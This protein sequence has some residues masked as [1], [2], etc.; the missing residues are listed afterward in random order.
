MLT[1]LPVQQQPLSQH[2]LARRHLVIID[3]ALAAADR[4]EAATRTPL[5]TQAANETAIETRIEA[6]TH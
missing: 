5:A 3:M 6:Q 2:E 4:A 1:T